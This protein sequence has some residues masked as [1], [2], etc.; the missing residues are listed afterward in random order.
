MLVLRPTLNR[1]PSR[2]AMKATLVAADGRAGS[3]VVQTP[4]CIELTQGTIRVL[5]VLYRPAGFF[6][7]DL[8]GDRVRGLVALGTLPIAP[9]PEIT[10]P[11]VGE[12]QHRIANPRTKE[13][14]RSSSHQNGFNESASDVG[15]HPRHCSLRTTSSTVFEL[16]LEFVSF[17]AGDFEVEH[18]VLDVESQLRERLLHEGQDAAAA[19]HGINDTM[20][21]QL[22]F[23]SCRIG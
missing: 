10:P 6:D 4:L 1:L 14:D 3:S 8:A 17:L 21:S 15:D 19:A 7:G 2:G 9:Y 5:E 13:T 18:Q 12:V 22:Q 11:H 16:L 20:I 23:S